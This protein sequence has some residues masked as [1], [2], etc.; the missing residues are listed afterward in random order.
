MRKLLPLNKLKKKAEKVF[1]KWIVKR[2]NYICYTCN[3]PGNQAGH[4][5]HNKLDFDERNLHCQCPAC[6]LW[7]SGNLA[8][9]GNRLL[10][11]YGKEWM[12]K[13]YSDAHQSLNKFDREELENIIEKY[14]LQ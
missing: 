12:D 2:D 3:K 11:E 7:K 4:Y 9:Y 1:H 6:N 5:W 8:E 14:G 10:N 13:L